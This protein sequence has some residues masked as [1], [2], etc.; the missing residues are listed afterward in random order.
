VDARVKKMTKSS[1]SPWGGGSARMDLSPEKPAELRR[2]NRI[3]LAAPESSRASNSVDIQPK[4]PSHMPH[5]P[6]PNSG[7]SASGSSEGVERDRGLFGSANF[8]GATLGEIG[9][10]NHPRGAGSGGFGGRTQSHGTRELGAGSHCDRVGRLE[11]A[12]A[13]RLVVW[14]E[15]KASTKPST[16][17]RERGV[18]WLRVEDLGRLK[19]HDLASRE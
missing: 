6:T 8:G 19:M 3:W 5:K 13:V 2:E 4:F 9:P 11:R 15:A 7:S 18:G 16:K 1:A 17:P 10:V 12:T 14:E